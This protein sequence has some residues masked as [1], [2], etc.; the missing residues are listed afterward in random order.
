MNGFLFIDKEKGATSFDVVRNVRRITGERRVGHAGTLDPLAT[1]LLIV[2]IGEGTKLLE[3]FVG[4][5]KE[6]EVLAHFGYKSDTYDA[7]GKIKEVDTEAVFKKDDIERIIEKSF[8]GEISQ[9][10]PKFSALKIE[11]RRAYDMARKGED[12]KLKPRKIK[13]YDFKIIDF[14][15]PKVS[16]RVKCGSGTYIR[17]LVNDLGENLGCGAYVE[18]LRRTKVGDFSVENADLS[19][20]IPLET[21]VG[22]FDHMELDDEG[23][24]GLK[25]GRILKNKK[26]E[27]GRAVMAFYKGKLVGVL[28]G[29]GCGIKYKKQIL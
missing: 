1:G 11:G 20:L 29:S 10:P 16:F 13:I 23:F 15:W 25:D 2:G 3:F 8:L 4:N 24:G 14:A 28:E 22:K 5:D 21:V 6:Y 18:G 17:S 9:M 12:V 27:Q 7:D 26:V 19:K